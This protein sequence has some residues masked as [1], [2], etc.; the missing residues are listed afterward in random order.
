MP[1]EARIGVNPLFSLGRVG[2]EEGMFAPKVAGPQAKAAEHSIIAPRP[3]RS[4]GVGRR[5][6]RATPDEVRAL[7][8]TIGNQA[9]V[10][11]LAPWVDGLTRN[12]AVADR[13]AGPANATARGSPCGAI[14]AKFAVAPVDDPLGDEALRP[15]SA[16]PQSGTGL[17][18]RLKFGIEALSGV[19]MDDVRVHYNSPQPAQ[20][21]ALAYAQG[22]DIHL[23]RG[24][25]MLL[26]HEAWHVV[27]QAQGRVR[28]TAR[29]SN[30]ATVSDDPELEREA[31][32]MGAKALLDAPQFRSE[33]QSERPDKRSPTIQRIVT[34]KGGGEEQDLGVVLQRLL[35][36]YVKLADWY[37]AQ[38]GP[39]LIQKKLGFGRFHGYLV[40]TNPDYQIDVVVP[41]KAST[42]TQN[43]VEAGVISALNSRLLALSIEKGH[44]KIGT[45]ELLGRS[46][47]TAAI[48]K[49]FDK[50]PVI[51]A[52]D[53]EKKGEFEPKEIHLRHFVM[54]SWFRALPAVIKSAGLSG[55][56]LTATH[57]RI[58]K[59]IPRVGPFAGKEGASATNNFDTDN[60]IL[61]SLLHDLLPN[62][63]AGEGAENTIIGF[64][65]N[66]LSNFAEDVRTG[67][68]AVARDDISS[69]I[70]AS[71]DGVT[72]VSSEIRDAYKKE[73]EPVEVFENLLQLRVGDADPVDPTALASV[74]HEFAYNLGM[75]LMKRD[76]GRSEQ[77]KNFALAKAQA[78][79]LPIGD[80][81]YSLI[82]K[83]QTMKVPGF[84]SQVQRG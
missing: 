50:V 40:A 64:M 25:E 63:N 6:G 44:S 66:G 61:A 39:K 62:L 37:K 12:E 17:P 35:G 15:A 7:Q 18:D 46:N 1:T 34:V 56:D 65:S 2:G 9:T 42:A 20:V 32:A 3:K 19:A 81:L 78:V 8:R 10:R 60:N 28:T 54:G 24:Q 5:S 13:G 74:L 67:N 4:V 77:T 58:A 16:L 72:I 14:M 47:F 49:S 36:P 31:D 80:A 26:P 38:I 59:L 48:K 70:E 71:V 43:E 33:P 84:R 29:L 22:A 82:V 57:E 55:G 75:D 45:V 76:V 21:N 52:L 83:A 41:Q 79:L 11:L 30:G 53:D 27:Q 23:A 51:K 73:F 69:L 68:K